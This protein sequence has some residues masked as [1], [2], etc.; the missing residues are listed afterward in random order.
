MARKAAAS[1]PPVRLTFRSEQH[2][3][4]EP[5]NKDRF[6]ITMREAA[7]ACKRAQDERDWQEDF[8][9][10]LHHVHQWC[11]AHKAK[12]RAGFVG[13]GDGALN[14][15]I[16]THAAD[17]DFDLDDQLTTLDTDLVDEFPWLIAEVIQIPASV[18]E[19]QTFPESVVIVYG[20]GK[21]A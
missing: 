1:P 21:R 19:D 20:D 13:V 12:V 5:D 6:L 17:Y 11:E 18:S 4:V 14:I 16:F 9:R 7:H 15:F 2:V 8:E 10:F 3:L